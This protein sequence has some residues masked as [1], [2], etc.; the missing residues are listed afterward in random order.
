M[1]LI[2]KIIITMV[3]LGIMLITMGLLFGAK[4]WVYINETGIHVEDTKNNMNQH[5]IE[6]FNLDIFEKVHIDVSYANIEII[7]SDNFGI[8]ILYYEGN[9]EILWSLENETLK[10]QDK[11]KE[12][13]YFMNFNFFSIFN[14][15]S[16]YIKIYIPE[17]V[18]LSDV[19]I[20]TSGGN[21]TICDYISQKTTINNSYGNV[22]IA[23]I[24]SE[25]LEVKL[26]SGNFKAENVITNDFDLKNSYGNGIFSNV[27]ANELNIDM[28]SGNINLKQIEVKNLNIKNSYGNI[29]GEDLVVFDSDIKTSSGDIKLSGDFLGKN[30][31][32]TSY[33]NIILNAAG[34]K[35]EYKLN[36]STSY[37]NVKI[38]G[39]RNE[40][41]S[42]LSNETLNG[43]ILEVEASSGN[44][45]VNFKTQ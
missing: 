20:E 8:E 23:N 38:D 24:E 12:N 33:G 28:S 16:D 35:E 10:I 34:I 31:I 18:E 27:E 13:F 1:K 29:T 43:K 9:P 11:K 41:N 3:I 45:E 4:L 21:V 15:E 14:W 30:K 42:L 2:Y 32:K 5:K 36:L 25:K 22:K 19:L 44:I 7:K 17:N 26:S 40:E 6:E 37:G 39:V